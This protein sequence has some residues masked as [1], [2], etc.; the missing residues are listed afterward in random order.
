MYKNLE[1]HFKIRT[2][3][4]LVCLNL[5]ELKLWML[6]VHFLLF[7]YFEVVI[8]GRWIMKLSE[9]KDDRSINLNRQIRIID[10]LWTFQGNF[11]KTL[12]QI[13]IYP[14]NYSAIDKIIGVSLKMNWQLWC[15]LKID[16]IKTIHLKIDKFYW[17]I[18]YLNLLINW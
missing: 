6:D 7:L 17:Y 10:D 3:Y 2:K 15:N 1:K 14:I 11:M 16:S 13:E 12:C 8:D 18:S 5:T 9:E 4:V